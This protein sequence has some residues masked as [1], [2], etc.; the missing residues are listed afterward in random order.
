MTNPVILGA[1]ENS[2]DTR[3]SAIDAPDRRIF[4]LDFNDVEDMDDMVSILDDMKSMAE[5]FNEV[6]TD[7]FGIDLDNDPA[8]DS[9]LNF[10]MQFY[11]IIAELE[12]YVEPG[13]EPEP[14]EDPEEDPNA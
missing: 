12:A 3:N 10:P 5:Y 7:E 14:E 2:A 13:E 9:V 8:L 4:E 1:G 11:E 6:L